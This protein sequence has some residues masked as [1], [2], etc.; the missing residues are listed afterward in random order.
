[1]QPQEIFDTVTRHLAKQGR[2]AVVKTEYGDLRC[3]YRAPDGSKCAAGA[4]LPD[5]SYDPEMEGAASRML[6]GRFN[7]PGWFV[8]NT[9]LI[10]RLQDAHD[11]HWIDNQGRHD[12]KLLAAE[13]TKIA[14][15]RHLNTDVIAEVFPVAA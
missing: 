6:P 10:Q 9:D 7:V 1:M 12:N 5:D 11:L 13:L 14:E 8:T 2:R 15:L 4:L 3:V